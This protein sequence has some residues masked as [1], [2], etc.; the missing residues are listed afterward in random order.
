MAVSVQ[1]EISGSPPEELSHT[2]YRIVQEGLTNARK[3]SPG[4]PVDVRLSGAPGPGLTVEVR[5]P[6]SA[7][8]AESG[9]RSGV[10]HHGHGLAGLSE[11]VTSLDGR[12]NYGP[13]ADGGWHLVAW[14]PWPA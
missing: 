3:H 11:R 14:L 2:V 7:V 10:G 5:N 1:D 4:L 8:P 9:Q 13:S 12:L 6:G